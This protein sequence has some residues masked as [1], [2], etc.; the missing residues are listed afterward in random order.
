VRE[1]YVRFVECPSFF[2][3]IVTAV[4]AIVDGNIVHSQQD[5][6]ARSLFFWPRRLTFRL[7]AL[8]YLTSLTESLVYITSILKLSYQHHHLYLRDSQRALGLVICR[9]HAMRGTADS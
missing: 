8:F 2:G 6:F 3:N 1:T 5:M 7:P 9:S 4:S